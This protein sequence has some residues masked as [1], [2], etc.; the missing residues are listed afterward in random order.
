MHDE[1][2]AGLTRLSYLGDQAQS[3]EPADGQTA[4]TARELLRSLDEIVWTV[5]PRKDRLEALAGYLTAWA[6]DFLRDTEV[7]PS[8]D[9]PVD[10]PELS[11]PANWRHE[12]FMI[13]KESLRNVLRH[14]RATEVRIHLRVADSQLELTIADNGIGLPASQSASTPALPGTLTPSEGVRDGERRPS[15]AR[16]S[17][18]SGDASLGGNGLANLRARAATLRGV[19][20]ITTPT[21]GGTRIT[22]RVPLPK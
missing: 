14:A 17:A 3:V 11:V 1:L 2:G 15:H 18:A 16:P 6:A 9:V 19:L 5:N 13:F 10:L 8:F 22:L 21:G 7:R 12:V 4:R 20:E